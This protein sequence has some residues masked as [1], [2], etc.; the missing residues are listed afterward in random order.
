M[1]CHFRWWFTATGYTD[2]RACATPWPPPETPPGAPAYCRYA[3]MP[4]TAFFS[5]S[6]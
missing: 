2:G 6:S 3:V 4:W 1:S 5:S